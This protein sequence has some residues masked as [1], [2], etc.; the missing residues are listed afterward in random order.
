VIAALLFHVPS[1]L[2]AGLAAWLLSRSLQ[3]RGLGRAG[4]AILG[5]L[6]G[7]LAG[8]LALAVLIDGL[9]GPLNLRARPGLGDWW[10]WTFVSEAPLY[11]SV[12]LAALAGALLPR[13]RATAP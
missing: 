8:F 6:A 12:P 7:I 10:S 3:G 2:S 9:A 4:A 11:T 5:T 13:R 1:A